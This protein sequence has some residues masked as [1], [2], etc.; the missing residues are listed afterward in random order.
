MVTYLFVSVKRGSAAGGV[1]QIEVH[2]RKEWSCVNE[3]ERTSDPAEVLG[4]IFS[5]QIYFLNL[6]TV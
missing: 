2:V 6:M 3:Q 5:L 4:T 1:D